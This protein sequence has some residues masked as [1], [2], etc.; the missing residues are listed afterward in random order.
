MSDEAKTAE[1]CPKCGSTNIAYCGK[2]D[3]DWRS[4]DDCEHTWPQPEEADVI[5]AARIEGARAMDAVWIAFIDDKLTAA[6]KATPYAI[7][8]GHQADILGQRRGFVELLETAGPDLDSRAVVEKLKAKPQVNIEQCPKCK[9]TKTCWRK[10][11]HYD[12]ERLCG[13]CGET[14]EP[15]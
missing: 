2:G 10:G 1:Q 15:E 6:I 14:Y 8:E 7:N 3:D 12:N 13:D 11:L 9:S 5:H 4:C